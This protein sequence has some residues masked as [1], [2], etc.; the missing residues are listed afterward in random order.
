MTTDLTTSPHNRQNILNNPYALSKVEEYLD[1]GG[2]LFEDEVL[3]TKQQVAQLFDIS[4]SMIEKYI[5]THASE[6]KNNGYKVLKGQKLRQFKALDF[7][8][9]NQ[10]RRQ[11]SSFRGFY[12][13]CYFKYSNATYRER[14]R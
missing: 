4:D 10:L 9:R 3:F 2:I 7:C 5:A 13:S 12:F 6:L 8:L 11:K 1:L 14:S